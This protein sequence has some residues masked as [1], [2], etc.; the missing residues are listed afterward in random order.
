MKKP[1]KSQKKD[2]RGNTSSVTF[3]TGL[4]QFQ[5]PKGLDFSGH[6]RIENMILGFM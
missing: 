2:P 5:E 6:K 4:Y 3:A 1:L